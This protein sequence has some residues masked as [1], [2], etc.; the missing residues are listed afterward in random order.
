MSTAVPRRRLVPL[1]EKAQLSQALEVL[2]ERAQ[3]AIQG[4]TEQA[5]A[6]YAL[7]VYLF[8]PVAVVVPMRMLAFVRIVFVL[9]A[10]RFGQVQQHA[11]KHQRAAQRR[12]HAR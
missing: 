9:V 11:G 4:D 5:R 3:E 6:G 8:A 10:M 1:A 2:P 7:A 12:Q